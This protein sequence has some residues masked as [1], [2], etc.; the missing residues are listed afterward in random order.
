MQAGTF[1]L[2]HNGV[3][4]NDL[5]LRKSLHLPRTRIET[6]SF[7]AVQLIEQKGIL[8]FDSLRY[9][10]ELLE[11][12][13]TITVLG[14]DGDLYI[15]KGDNPFCLYFFPDCGLYLYASTEEILRQALRKIQVSLGK[16]RKVSIQCGE[17]LRINQTGRLD[18]ETFDDSKLFRCRYPRFLMNDP[19]C[20]SFPHAAEGTTHLDELKTVALAFGYSPGDV[21]LLAAQGFTADELEDLFYSG[22][23]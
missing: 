3:L 6:D 10:A 1:A 17:I 15:V 4:D 23:I 18:R 22:E 20:R 8:I 12:S 14:D 13:F 19:Y 7:I 21:D 11:G 16:S 2:A 5:S 9:M